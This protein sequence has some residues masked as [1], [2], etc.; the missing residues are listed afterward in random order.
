[1]VPRN[2]VK[3]LQ[4]TCA[5]MSILV[6]LP[7]SFYQLNSELGSGAL[8][9]R[10]IVLPIGSHWHAPGLL[11]ATLGRCTSSDGYVDVL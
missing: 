5:Y 9:F 11:Q 3:K 2:S 1:M 7:L 10:V 4:L 6:V 8:H